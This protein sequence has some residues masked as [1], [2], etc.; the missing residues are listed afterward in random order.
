MQVVNVAASPSH[1]PFIF[2]P[3]D[4]FSNPA[5]LFCF[6]RLCCLSKCVQN[7]SHLRLLHCSCST[8]HSLKG[9]WPRPGKEPLVD[10]DRAVL[11]AIHHQ[12]AVLTAIRPLPQRHVPLA[13]A[14]MAHPGRIAFVSDM[15]F[16]PK[17]Q[18][19]VLKHLHKAIETPI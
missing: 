6:H 18:T 2:Y 11:I 17:A 5:K 13:L 15:Q 12:A 16:F 4:W 8:P 7:C 10:V 9:V 14:H 1:E 19:L 3:G